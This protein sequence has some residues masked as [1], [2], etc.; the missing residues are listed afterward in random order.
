[1]GRLNFR[2]Y[3]ILRFYPAREIREKMC[4]LQYALII[5]CAMSDGAVL[6]N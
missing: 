1:M 5:L 2:G 3:L 6:I 4:L